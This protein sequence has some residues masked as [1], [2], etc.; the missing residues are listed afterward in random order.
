MSESQTDC[1]ECVFCNLQGMD[2]AEG[3]TLIGVSIV[4]ASSASQTQDSATDSIA[5]MGEAEAEAET[6]DAES[7][8]TE[9]EAAEGD[10]EASEGQESMSVDATVPTV[11]LVTAQG[12]G[13]RV[14]V[15]SFKLQRRG[16]M[17]TIAIKCNAGDKLVALHVV[18]SMHDSLSTW[19]SL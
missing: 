13:K 12:L 5:D 8:V 14:P 2:F 1:E 6:A 19:H 10:S 15:E 16:G 7:E 4:P 9:S 3:Q 17:G 18:G 11:L